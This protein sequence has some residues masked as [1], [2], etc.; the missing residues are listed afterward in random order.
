VPVIRDAGTAGLVQCRLC[1]DGFRRVGG[2]HV[3]SQRLG[4][5][6]DT[7]CDRVFA[8]HGGNM[9]DDNS[10]PWM[11]HVD[12]DPLRRQTGDARRYASAEAAYDAAARRW[13]P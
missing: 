5:I 7:P 11:A 1:D 4:M 9:T 10:R 13:H 3:G 2:T 6:D 12:G 8:V